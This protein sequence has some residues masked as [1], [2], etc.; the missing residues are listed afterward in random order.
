M[1][2]L[3]GM[4]SK[5]ELTSSLRES[6]CVDE[7]SSKKEKKERKKRKKGEKMKKKRKNDQQNRD[8]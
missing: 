2:S 3:K 8:M 1:H 4:S 7:S 5:H 6:F